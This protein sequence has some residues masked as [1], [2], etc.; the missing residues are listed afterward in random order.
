LV[1]SS[2][3]NNFGQGNLL[4]EQLFDDAEAVEAG[5]LHIEKDEVGIVFADE[6]HS[7]DTILALSYDVNVVDA[8]EEESEFVSRQLLVVH[9]HCG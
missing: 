3:E 4:V 8:L 9:D 5:H 6:I 2:S 7:F 1:E